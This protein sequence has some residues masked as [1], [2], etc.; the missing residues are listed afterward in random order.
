MFEFWSLGIK[1][2]FTKQYTRGG[3]PLHELCSLS[4]VSLWN[5]VPVQIWNESADAPLVFSRYVIQKR[6]RHKASPVISTYVHIPTLALSKSGIR[7]E[8]NYFL[9]ACQYKL[10]CLFTKFSICF[11]H[12]SVKSWFLH[13]SFV[14][15]DK[16][17]RGILPVNSN[18]NFIHK[19]SPDLSRLF[20]VFLFL[21]EVYQ[22]LSIMISWI[23]YLL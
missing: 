14:Q 12:N 1:K 21:K 13:I 6:R 22:F 20:S 5:C 15:Y 9:S 16:T 3:A 4:F 10:P 18:Y 2:E 17:P 7:V 19:K 8:V 11:N 23:F